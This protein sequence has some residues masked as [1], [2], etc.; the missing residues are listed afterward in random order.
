LAT[1]IERLE[2]L[3][4][5]NTAQFAKAMV[6]L[7]GDTNKALTAA[8]RSVAGFDAR[9]RSLQATVGKVAGMFGVAFG[10]GV[11]TNFINSSVKAGAAVGDLAA[12][13]AITAEATQQLTYAT[14]QSGASVDALA[15][16]FKTMAGILA[17]AARGSKSAKDQLAELGLTLADFKGKRPD[18]VFEIL[19]N[20]IG[21][22]Q[23]PFVRTNELV[24]FFGKSGADLAQ[25]ADLGGAGIEKL[26]QKFV[27]LGIQL[28]NEEVAKLKAAGD[29]LAEIGA[30]GK[31][32]G[33]RM[34]IAFLPTIDKLDELITDPKFQKGLADT[35]ARIGEIVGFLVD[36]PQLIGILGG[37]AV[38]SRFGPVG[39]GI[40][41]VLGGAASG[42]PI[43]GPGNPAGGANP[44]PP[45]QRPP[46]SIGAAAGAAAGAPNVGQLVPKASG[47]SFDFGFEPNLPAPPGPGITEANAE[48]LHKAIEDINN[49]LEQSIALSKRW[50]DALM[51]VG[52]AA[53]DVFA[54]I[55]DGTKDA[56]TA[57]LDFIKQLA[58]AEAK[59]AFLHLLNPN[60]ALGP[61]AT[62]LGGQFPGLPGRAS[63]GPVMAGMPYMVGE[64]GPELFIPHSAGRIASRGGANGGAIEVHIISDASPLFVQNVRV[65]STD[66]A[67]KVTQRGLAQYHRS[68]Q[69]SDLT[70][71][72][73]VG[74][75]R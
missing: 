31:T 68:Q 8:S 27:S 26:R 54:G 14:E 44:L 50:T 33:E 29:K 63:G 58:L 19:L 52:G 16:A 30:A 36:H 55:L 57:I 37:A 3:I 35:A 51:D 34:A 53:F 66:I 43:V 5:A 41:A 18:Q 73:S 45:G 72:A 49:Q 65:Q 12:K 15:P 17:D 22:L 1:D 10:V 69:R 9:L 32:A 20:Q 7:Q 40:G 2:V 62:L 75:L 47:P 24:K 6:K 13:L 60:S 70:G 56:K 59:A 28:S 23:D 38:G 39:A 74:I 71:A 46:L 42:V 64:R 21:R 67:V 25:L 48:R 61:I 11:M 4:E